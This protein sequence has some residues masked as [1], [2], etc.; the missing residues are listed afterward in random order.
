MKGEYVA[1]GTPT[2]FQWPGFILLKPWPSAFPTEGRQVSMGKSRYLWFVLMPSLLVP[3]PVLAKTK[4]SLSFWGDPWQA[5]LWQQVISEFEAANPDIDVESIHI[6]GNYAEKVATMIAAGTAPDVMAWEDKLGLEFAA[7][8]A[9][10]DLNKY[11]KAD[12]DFR[13]SD[14]YGIAVDDLSF[15]GTQW[16]LPWSMLTTSLVYNRDMFIQSGLPLPSPDWGN[17]HWNWDAF[18]EAGKKLTVD[19]DGDRVIDRWGFNNIYSW[20]RW[21]IFV[22]QSGGDVWDDAGKTVLLQ[23]PGSLA[24]LQFLSDINHV[25][26]FSPLPGQL[27]NAAE[28]M[29]QGKAAMIMWSSTPRDLVNWSI[30]WDVAAFPRGPV[31]NASV[32]IPDGIAISRATAVP[33]AAW[34]LVKF[35][36]GPGQAILAE[37]GISPNRRYVRNFLLPG[38]REQ[39]DVF[40]TAVDHGK[41]VNYTTKWTD[42]EGVLRREVIEPILRGTRSAEQA[43]EVAVPLLKVLL[44]EA[45]SRF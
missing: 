23:Q 42:L 34:K 11:I 25:Y 40:L 19:R 13:L 28:A 4:V 33:D 15:K 3:G 12:R 16:A 20:S 43:V 21:R 8:G 30:P 31:R 45:Q 37:R 17:P 26:R 9:F 27:G 2:H 35:V 36:S 10:L 14:F 5:S 18:V 39:L 6:T 41:V 29:N 44:Q 38:R 32:V 24:G 7:K 1:R 22:W